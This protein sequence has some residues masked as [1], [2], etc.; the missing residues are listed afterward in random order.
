MAKPKAPEPRNDQAERAIIS[1]ILFYEDGIR[2]CVD[3]ELEAEH[4]YLPNHRAIYEA[5]CW[6]LSDGRPATY[7]AV[8]ERLESLPHPQGAM[9][10]FVGGASEITRYIEDF[11]RFGETD[12]ADDIERVKHASFQRAT[13]AACGKLAGLAFHHQG[14]T[15]DLAAQARA[16]IDSVTTKIKP[17]KNTANISPRS[18]DRQTWSH[19][20]LLSQDFTSQEWIVEGLVLADDLTFI[21]GKKKLG[22]SIFC[23]QA[24]VAVAMGSFLLGRKCVRGRVVYLCLEDGPRRLQGRLKRQEALVGLDIEYL[25]RFPS[26]DAG[27]LEALRDLLADRRPRLVILDTLAACKTGRIDENAAGDM[28]DLTNALRILAQDYHVAILVVVHHGKTSTGD[29]GFDMR[30]S[31]AQPGA[32]AVNIGLYRDE[33]G[34]YTLKAEGRDIENQ[35]LRIALDIPSLSWGLVGDARLLARQEADGEILEALDSLGEADAGTVARGCGRARPT[36]I[37]VLKRLANDGTIVS[38]SAKVDGRSKILY[39]RMKH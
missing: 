39:G 18:E 22:K 7:T 12:L 32:T 5:A 31:S 2:A 30:G 24:A 28:A 15:A 17:P 10:D 26:L 20:D 14:T 16:L 35:E 13:M 25:T 33:S 29:P 27:G 11:T 36:V 9:L 19:N 37:R 4:F 38:R 1:H 3:L 23:L 8:I 34:T 21:G 6:L